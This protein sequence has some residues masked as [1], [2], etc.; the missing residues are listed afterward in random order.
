MQCH[1]GGHS[2]VSKSF[3]IGP[4]EDWTEPKH[5][6]WFCPKH[7]TIPTMWGTVISSKQWHLGKKIDSQERGCT[8]PLPSSNS[9]LRQELCL[10]VLWNWC[11]PWEHEWSQNICTLSTMN[12]LEQ[13]LWIA[14][15]WR[16][17]CPFQW[18]DWWDVCFLDGVN[19]TL[20]VFTCHSFMHPSWILSMKMFDFWLECS[21]WTL[22][23]WW[24]NL[25]HTPPYN[26]TDTAYYGDNC[27]VS[28]IAAKKRE[29]RRCSSD[30]NNTPHQRSLFLRAK[31]K[32]GT[33][34]VCRHFSVFYCAG[35]PTG[36]T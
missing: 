27:V 31:Q 33:N 12:C 19:K 20:G 25:P 1:F 23:K 8:S 11:V 15:Q 22:W 10:E 3:R 24:L 21:L 9:H 17:S 36:F 2:T 6:D 32:E 35:R 29:K 18:L 5:E 28:L 34:P 16:I 4:S 30:N 14:W 13:N 26:P 7:W